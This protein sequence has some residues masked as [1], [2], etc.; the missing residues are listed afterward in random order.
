MEDPVPESPRQVDPSG[1]MATSRA[2]A[3]AEEGR[4]RRQR[5]IAI[6]SEQPG[7]EGDYTSDPNV[8]TTIRQLLL[9][10]QSV[11]TLMANM[12]PQARRIG[13]GTRGEK[14]RSPSPPA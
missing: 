5:E 2:A 12:A 13:C 10:L 8:M 6:P 3:R 11:V 9:Y 4:Q 7:H 1:F 14:R